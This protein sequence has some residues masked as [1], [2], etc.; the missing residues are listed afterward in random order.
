LGFSPPDII[1]G[2]PL[3][4]SSVGEQARLGL[5][6]WERRVHNTNYSHR[7][8]LWLLKPDLLSNEEMHGTFLFPEYFIIG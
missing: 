5:T 6:F 1:N 7:V 2:K 4:H 8:M 3:Q